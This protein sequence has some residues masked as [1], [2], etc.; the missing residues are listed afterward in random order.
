MAVPLCCKQSIKDFTIL[1]LTLATFSPDNQRCLPFPRHTTAQ[2]EHERD[3]LNYKFTF[4]ASILLL[5]HVR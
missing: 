3:N 1:E 5:L 2:P 4:A